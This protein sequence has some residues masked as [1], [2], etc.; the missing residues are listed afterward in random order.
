M[1]NAAQPQPGRQRPAA[2]LVLAA[3]ER[4]QR[5]GARAGA[6]AP[7]SASVR[8]VLEHLAVHPRSA[9]GRAV[10]D[11]L[12][13]LAEEGVLTRARRRGRDVFSLTPAGR[14]RLRRGRAAAPPADLPESPQHQAWR[15]ARACAALELAR[16]RASLGRAL[17]D[18]RRLLEADP[19]PHSDEWL[20]LGERLRAAARRV[21]SAWH[22]LHEWPEPDDALA[23][24]DDLGEPACG[25]LPAAEAAHLRAL[26]AGRRNVRL[27][28]PGGS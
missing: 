5:H 9:Q 28:S 14:R 20:V 18:G 21:G 17:A 3:V 13:T 23:D 22:C 11:A 15:N 24:V 16:F 25:S 8:S 19:P 2:M 4:A 6:P 26:R 1:S 10:R 12:R 27:W 7:A